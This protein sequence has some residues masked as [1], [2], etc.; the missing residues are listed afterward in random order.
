ME[1]PIPSRS[2]RSNVT[3]AESTFE[4]IDAGEGLNG[5][6]FVIG[7][8]LALVA[9]TATMGAILSVVL[10]EVETSLTLFG[11]ISLPPTALGF[12]LY[13]GLTVAAILGVPLLAMFYISDRR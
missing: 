3:D 2:D 7:L 11:F 5:R 12:A 1:K 13:G 8:Y 6:R 10:T 9:V 4:G